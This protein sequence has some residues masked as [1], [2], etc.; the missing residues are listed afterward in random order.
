MN[1]DFLPAVAVSTV[2]GFIGFEITMAHA[3]V[4]DKHREDPTSITAAGLHRYSQ[5]EPPGNASAFSRRLDTD[6]AGRQREEEKEMRPRAERCGTGNDSESTQNYRLRLFVAGDHVNSVKARLA[7]ARL[8]DGQLR[9]RC[10]LHVVDVLEDDY[11]A[12]MDQP[13]VAVPALVVEGPFPLKV[14][15]GSLG[16][17]DKL[18]ATLGLMGH[19]EWP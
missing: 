19:G 2:Y 9:D 6:R 10:E 8:C 4:F 5:A 12:V 7:L 18:L 15:V 11:Q 13:L 17:E 14:I 3:S 1:P 16:D